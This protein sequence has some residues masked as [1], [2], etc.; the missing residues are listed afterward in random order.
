[1][2]KKI[3]FPSSIFVVDNVVQGKL[4][5]SRFTAVWKYAE[6]NG[7]KYETFYFWPYVRDALNFY[8]ITD[9]MQIRIRYRN[10]IFYCWCSLNIV[11]GHNSSINSCSRFMLN[12]HP[13]SYHIVYRSI[14]SVYAGK[15]SCLY[16]QYLIIT[17]SIM[18]RNLIQLWG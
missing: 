15:F 5:K 10:V 7:R 16:K 3:W 18:Y 14:Y 6:L 17:Q 9:R 8:E 11:L 4:N 1:M 12:D 13:T 2:R